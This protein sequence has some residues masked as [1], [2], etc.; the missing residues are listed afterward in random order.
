MSD[1]QSPEQ[2]LQSLLNDV[3][4][5]RDLITGD[6]SQ[7][8]EKI[9][10]L[11]VIVHQPNTFI[12]KTT[13]YNIPSSN[14]IKFVGRAD[15]LEQ[16]HQALQQNS[17]VA[18]T[19]IEGMGG[20]GK[21]EL[22]T[23][24]CLLHLLL[25]TYPGGICWLR[26]RDEDVGIQILRFAEAKL[27]IEPPED[28]DIKDQVDFCWSRWQEK[29][30]GNVLIVL[31]DVNDYPK[32][33][34]Y[35]PPQLSQFKVLIT[36]R[37]HLDLPQSFSLDI[38]SES[39]SLELLKQW[40][41][42]EKVNEQLTEA[43]ELCLRLGYLPLALNLVGRYAQKRKI[44]LAEMLR[45]LEEKGLQHKALDVD[46]KDPTRTLDIQR[47][48][49]AAFELSW[50]ELSED[51]QKLGC[52]LSLFELAPI[53]WELAKQ[54]E[55]DLDQEELEESLLELSNLHLIK[56]DN[57]K[58]YSLHNLIKD[59]FAQKLLDLDIEEK[60][61][62]FANRIIHYLN[63]KFT[64]S[65]SFKRIQIKSIYI[66]HIEAIAKYMNVWLEKNNLTICMKIIIKFYFFNG[67]L[68]SAEHWSKFW[69]KIC[70]SRFDNRS[71]ILSECL[72][73]VS[74]VLYKQNK[75]KQAEL[76]CRQAFDIK[77]EFPQDKELAEILHNLALI[78][79]AQKDYK[80]AGNYYDQ[81]L[82]IYISLVEKKNSNNYP[83][84]ATFFN[85][86]GGLYSSKKEYK[87]AEILFLKSLSIRKK[88]FGEEHS[89]VAAS[90][91]NLAGIYFFQGE[92]IKAEKLYLKALNIR[93]K[94]F[95]QDHPTVASSLEDLGIFYK[96]TN[97]YKKAITFYCK[98]L[99][100]RKKTLGERHPLINKLKLELYTMKLNSDI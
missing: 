84:I 91:K 96:S 27:G 79:Q 65:D 8:I 44:S 85:N 99:E 20:V 100:I 25:N 21:T 69:L 23:Q 50:E 82:R 86:M 31:D 97:R 62:E 88:Y 61:K 52:C 45:R 63:H 22:V 42:D 93:E 24:Y 3:K 1:S 56:N 92:L 32:I 6:I 36:T 47:G 77:K 13:P 55:N 70:K 10:N 2:Q 78:Y 59:F 11:F 15:A 28:W 76:F 74:L 54:I 9:L 4:V 16:V 95:G 72:N 83:E 5:G 12:P 30:E 18:I 49:A 58:T 29:K 80:K 39:A 33:Q 66:P 19:A 90:L 14:T 73:T 57:T 60:K 40:M 38:L 35:L 94:L 53:P 98:T 87:K 68:N 64:A 51:T 67:V 71:I 46:K 37:L 81:A 89:T 43:K 7:K 41:G 34:P 75:I 26:A 48:V 17:Q